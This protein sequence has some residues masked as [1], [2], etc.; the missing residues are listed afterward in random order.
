MSAE[1]DIP[2]AEAV[3]CVVPADTPV[4]TPVVLLIVATVGALLVQAKVT[5][6]MVLP[7]LS[8]A[9]AVNC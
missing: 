4:A 6:L 9:V 8:F 7:L 1:L 2:L 3:I 5:P